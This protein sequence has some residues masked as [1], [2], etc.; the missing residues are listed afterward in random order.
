MRKNR[1]DRAVVEGAGPA[2]LFTTFHLFL[3]GM[4]VLLVNDRPE[5]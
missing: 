4:R 2:G 5:L 1:F 3:A